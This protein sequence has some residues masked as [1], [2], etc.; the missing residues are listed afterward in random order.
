MSYA[1]EQANQPMES[2]MYFRIVMIINRE[3]EGRKLEH[4]CHSGGPR[5]V[6]VNVKAMDKM[7]SMRAG[8]LCVDEKSQM[9]NEQSFQQWDWHP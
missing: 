3:W 1:P 7:H 6:N 8:S 2:E 4:A 5:Y 9:G